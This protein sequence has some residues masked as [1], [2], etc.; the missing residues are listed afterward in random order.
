MRKL[1]WTLTLQ[2]NQKYPLENYKHLT[3]VDKSLIRPI[4]LLVEMPI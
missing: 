2:V 3:T 4:P 1:D